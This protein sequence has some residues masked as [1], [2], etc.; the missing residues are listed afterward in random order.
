MLRWR[1][2]RQRLAAARHAA[3][4]GAWPDAATAYAAFLD[5]R[6]RNAAA[7]VQYGHAR[8]ATGDLDVAREAYERAATLAPNVADTWLQMA[9]VLRRLGNRAAAIDCC[10][11]ALTIDPGFDAATEE[12]LGLGGRDQVPGGI[13]HHGH[14]GVDVD[15]APWL[16]AVVQAQSGDVYAPGRYADYRRAL[17]IPTPPPRP[18][19]DSAILVLIDA[20]A[21]MP[22]DVRATLSSLRDQ[23]DPAWSARVIAPAAIRDHSVASLAAID[24]RIVFADSPET[25]PAAYV[26]QVR[27]GTVLDRQAIAWFSHVAARTGCAAAYADHDHCIDD[28]RTGRRH[29]TPV[30]QPMPDPDWFADEAVRPALL[31][32]DTARVDIT[33]GSSLLAVR[34]GQ[35]TVAHIPLL[36]ASVR[37]LASQALRAQAE[38]VA[39]PAAIVRTDS[40]SVPTPDRIHVVVQTRDAPDLLRD[41][42]DSLHRLAARPDLLRITIVDN[43]S[44]LP[45]TARLLARYA[46]RGIAETLALDEPFNWS[47]ANNL[48]VEGSAAP[49]LLFLNN[50]TTSLTA[51]WDSALRDAMADPAVGAVGALLL[52]PDGS[53]QHA[54]M[55]FGI[56]SGGPIHEGIGHAD[57]DSGPNGRWSRVR[58]AAAVTGAFLA[59]RRSVFEAIGGFDAARLSIAFND[60][61]LCLRVREAGYRIVQTPAIRLVHHE[62]KTRG[63]NVTRSQVAWDLEEL[64]VV[65]RRWGAA[66]FEDPGYNPHWTRAGQ[67]F[68][69]YRFPAMRETL[70]HIDRSARPNP[71]QVSADPATDQR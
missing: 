9:S 20:Q 31:L 67:P 47:R 58:S 18:R 12:L 22:V 61:D 32:V 17:T 38:P 15:H 28:W 19:L 66:L 36:L 51:G 53:I 34:D 41:A 42:V 25:P 5:V 54:G 3:R 23:T 29:D 46:G 26:L 13:S 30:F 8:K 16:E 33:L 35:P 7:W 6:P 50:D 44:A 49:V 69:G 39:T 64:T 62:S 10:V 4:A 52:Y 71:W 60:V 37:A 40:P 2:A 43:R 55:I 48:A 1:V 65:H 59:V 68:D 45:E 14:E 27:A 56:G 57:G 11:R 21:A 63:L 70:D 24:P